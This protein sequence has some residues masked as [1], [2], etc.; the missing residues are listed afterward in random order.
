MSW[1]G[2]AAFCAAYFVAVATP[3]PGVAAVLAQGLARGTNGAAA[4]IAGFL[5]GDLVWFFAAALGLSALAQTAQTAFLAVKYAGAAYL[6][7]LAYKLWT[8]P[9]RPLCDG[10]VESAERKPWALFIGSLTLCLSNPKAMIFFIAL[11][12]SVVHLE[13]LDLSGYLK[14]AAAMIVIQ[15]LILSGYVLIA[16]RARYWLRTPRALKILNR[17]S[18]TLLTA[19]AVAVATR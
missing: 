4:F 12:P 1:Y 11:L 15:P 2:L 13:A 16:T 5:V 8:A 17:G 6:L 3:G 19:A 9:V 18:G 14:I 10:C 7:Y